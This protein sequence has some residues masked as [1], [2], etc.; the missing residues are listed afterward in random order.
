MQHEVQPEGHQRHRWR[1]GERPAEHGLGCEPA[2]LRNNLPRRRMEQ[3]FSRRRL[4][5]PESKDPSAETDKGHNQNQ[6]QR[7][8]RVVGS[9]NRRHVQAERQSQ[10]GAYNRC[11]PDKRN[12]ADGEAQRQCERQPRGRKP[13]PQPLRDLALGQSH[14]RTG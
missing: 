13:L 10:R 11:G 4:L 7:H 12:A 5:R 6:L 14:G 2:K 9:L 8:C 3:L 1:G